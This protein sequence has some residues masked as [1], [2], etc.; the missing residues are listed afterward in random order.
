ML[1][2]DVERMHTDA[3]EKLDTLKD[4]HEY[5]LEQ[6]R[7]LNAQN[8]ELKIQVAS[9]HLDCA[10]LS[11]SNESLKSRI[12]SFQCQFEKQL[13]DCHSRMDYQL[14]EFSR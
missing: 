5:V 14:M 10:T 12:T 6:N 11:K 8:D 13:L 3:A 9:L 4:H 7:Q 1:T 2:K